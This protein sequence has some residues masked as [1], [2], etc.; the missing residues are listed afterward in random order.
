M[1]HQNQYQ[2]AEKD[3]LVIAGLP[4]ERAEQDPSDIIGSVAVE[5]GFKNPRRGRLRLPLFYFSI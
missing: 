2:C 3:A 4:G 5:Q 1:A